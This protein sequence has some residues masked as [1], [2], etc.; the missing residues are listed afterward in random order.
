LVLSSG[1]GLAGWSLDSIDTAALQVCGVCSGCGVGGGARHSIVVV[2]SSGH[3]WQ[4][5]VGG[6]WGLGLA[7]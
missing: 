1:G 6:Y 7:G 5:V 3:L 2:A 4:S